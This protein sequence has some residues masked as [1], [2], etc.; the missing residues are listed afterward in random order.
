MEEEDEER[1]ALPAW[2]ES[3]TAA[4]V[5]RVL[6]HRKPDAARRRQLQ[7]ETPRCNF[8]NRCGNGSKRVLAVA[9]RYT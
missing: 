2:M 4:T 8:A 7:Y 9:I 5:Q 1:E 6:R 3:D